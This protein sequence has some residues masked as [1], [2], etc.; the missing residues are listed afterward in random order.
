MSS[1]RFI[2][3]FYLLMAVV[4]IGLVEWR[5]ESFATDPL[6]LPGENWFFALLVTAW[7]VAI[8]HLL[9]RLAHAKLRSL[10]HGG[11]DLQRILGNVTTGQIAVIALMSGIG[12]EILFRGWLYHETGLWASSIIFGLVHVPPNR[13]W[14]YWPIFA[15]AMGIAFGWIYDWSG[16]LLFPILLHA[17]INFLNLRTLLKKAS[18]G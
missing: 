14:L 17:G 8:V 11:R 1:T 12:E 10:Q 9:S 7:L 6:A 3:L 13:K 15:T 4:G 2:S 16:S 5:K 18:Q